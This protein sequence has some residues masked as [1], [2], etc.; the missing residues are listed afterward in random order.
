MWN[1]VAGSEQPPPLARRHPE[2]LLA[3][4]PVPELSPAEVAVVA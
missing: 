3:F 1:L 4:H 2:F